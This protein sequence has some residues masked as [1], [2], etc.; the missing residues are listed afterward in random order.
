[1][2]IN[3]RLGISTS[4]YVHD[5]N[6]LLAEIS[7]FIKPALAQPGVN[8]TAT[9]TI[10]PPEK[11]E[12]WIYWL[13]EITQQLEYEAMDAYP[14]GSDAT[15]LELSIGGVAAVL[16]IKGWVPMVQILGH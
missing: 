13:L 12:T 16:D 1:M 5:L 2:A 9:V 6:A 15:A 7:R 10:F 11:R 4:L 3:I 14:A 8:Y